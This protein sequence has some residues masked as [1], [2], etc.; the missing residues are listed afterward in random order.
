MLS[1]H[2]ANLSMWVRCF[3][4]ECLCKLHNSYVS[5]TSRSLRLVVNQTQIQCALFTLTNHTKPQEVHNILHGML[6]EQWAS[7]A[8]IAT[9]P[10]WTDVWVQIGVLVVHDCGIFHN[11]WSTQCWISMHY[12][13]KMARKLNSSSH[14]VPLQLMF[15]ELSNESLKLQSKSKNV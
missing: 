6:T 1:L 10:F 12:F 4:R 7:S 5:S 13:M 11:K 15:I 3:D 14:L 2:V 8:L 9:V